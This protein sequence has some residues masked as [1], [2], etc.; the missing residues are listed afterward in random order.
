MI[1]RKFDSPISAK[2]GNNTQETKKEG[3]VEKMQAGV[4]N[5]DDILLLLDDSGQD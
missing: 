2:E 4:A 1:T 5:L 3:V